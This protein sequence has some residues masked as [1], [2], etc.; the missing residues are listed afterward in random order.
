[1]QSDLDIGMPTVSLQ[2]TYKAEQEVSSTGRDHLT[3]VAELDD[4]HRHLYGSD[5]LEDLVG[6]LR[7]IRRWQ[8]PTPIIW[9]LIA[10]IADGVLLVGLL[11]LV[12]VLAAP[13]QLKLQELSGPFG[14]RDAKFVWVCL[15]LVSW[16]IALSITEA[17]DFSCV[18]SLLKSPLWALS[19]LVLMLVF[20]M[21]LTYFFV[22]GEVLS[23]TG[24]MLFFLLLAAP[25]FCSW[26]VALAE[27][28]KLP[29]FCRRAVIVGADSAGEMIA[30]ELRSV[31]HPGINILGYISESIDRPEP[32]DGSSILGGGNV[33]R[34]LARN[35]MIDMVIMALDYKVNPELFQEAFEASQLGI[36]VVPTSVVYESTSGKIPLEHICDQWYVALQSER[37]ISPLYLCWHKVMDLASGLCG[38]AVLV[39]VLPVL[40][41]LIALDSPGPIFYSQERAGYQGRTFRILKFR[42]MSTY[43]EQ[44]G[45]NTWATEGDPRVTRVGRLMRAIH[46]DELPQVLNILRGN[47]SLIGPRPERPVY[48]DEL[49]KSNPF[50]SYRLSVKPG[51]TGWA[52]V[53]YGYGSAEQD[54][55]VKLQYDL[56][57]IKHRSFLLDVLIILK[58][59]IEVVLGHGV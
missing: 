45:T 50:Y 2:S 47:M 36:S 54:E 40:A 48:V 59:V 58:T 21:A 24:I 30:R 23:Y 4:E 42:S 51:L 44:S 11:M 26:R 33:L 52:Q 49:T 18:S 20:W 31:K 27:I 22:G 34:R 12:L 25:A 6:G 1:M 19:T 28:I 56:F 16:G 14:I 39:L 9:R 37:V 38:L 57:Y 55:L 53:K 15:A 32:Q 46:L 13:F 3:Q 43:A 41:A 8:R 10:M 7:G 29:R 35:G 5:S 17:Q